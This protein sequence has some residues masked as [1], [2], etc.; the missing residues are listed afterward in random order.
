LIRVVVVVGHLGTP[1]TT[2]NPGATTRTKINT[3]VAVS[4]LTSE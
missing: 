4:I 3:Q 2:T 1:Q